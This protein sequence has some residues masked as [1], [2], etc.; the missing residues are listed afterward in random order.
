M[1]GPP[2]RLTISIG[3]GSVNC[4]GEN[5]GILEWFRET[6]AYAPW[7]SEFAVSTTPVPGAPQIWVCE[8]RTPSVEYHAENATAVLSAPED[9]LADGQALAYLAFWISEPVRQRAGEI[10]FHAGG[11]CTESGGGCLIVG[12]RGA[13]KTSLILELTR[14]HRFT[15]IANDI[16][17]LA[18]DRQRREISLTGGSKVIGLRLAAARASFPELLYYF[19]ETD[20]GSWWNK[21]FIDPASLGICTCDHA[22]IHK[23]FLVHLD[24]T[25]SDELS[26]YP[27]SDKWI[28][29]YLHENLS[30]YIRASALLVFGA[31]TGKTLGYLP[32][33]D[34]AELY[35]FRDTVI[36][37]LI[38]RVCVL[39]VSSGDVRRIAD[40]VSAEMGG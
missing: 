10:T 17:M 5:E 14:S 26:C 30:R 28:R 32:S 9:E 31:A 11:A 15:L 16:A 2:Y 25:G 36:E 19:H 34:Q 20:R 6:R 39:N 37:Y 29:N 7:L 35:E 40:L 18:Y 33:L 22:P 38:E 13:G 3:R 21:A 1:S 12:E 24:T 27:M 8:R 4:F 23:A